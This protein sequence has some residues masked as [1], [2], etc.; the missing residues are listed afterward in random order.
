MSLLQAV[1][2]CHAV[3]CQGRQVPAAVLLKPEGGEWGFSEGPQCEP[4]YAAL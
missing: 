2:I 3:Q 1:S 4:D